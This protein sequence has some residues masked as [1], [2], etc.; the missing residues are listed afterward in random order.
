MAVPKKRTSS[1]K[2]KLRNSG[3]ALKKLNIV[4][5]KSTGEPGLSHHVSKKSGLYRGKVVLQ[6]RVRNTEKAL[7]DSSDDE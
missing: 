1:M 6:R 3:S 7:Q 2:R 4:F 5:D